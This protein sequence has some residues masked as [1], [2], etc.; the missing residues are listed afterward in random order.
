MAALVP[1]IESLQTTDPESRV[2]AACGQR[3]RFKIPLYYEDIH[4]WVHLIG[5]GLGF[6]E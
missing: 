1:P 4:V 6:V 2:R 3:L 5:L